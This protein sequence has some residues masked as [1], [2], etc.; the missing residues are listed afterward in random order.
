MKPQTP[1]QLAIAT[2]MEKNPEFF[3]S[4]RT[5]FPAGSIDVPDE[6]KE[7]I[8]QAVLLRTRRTPEQILAATIASVKSESIAHLLSEFTAEPD[9]LSFLT[10]SIRV[11]KHESTY[12]IERVRLAAQRAAHAR[13]LPPA[14][15]EVVYAATIVAAVRYLM[16]PTI[17]VSSPDD[18]VFTIVR[19]ALH[20]LDDLA[21]PE[22]QL[23]RQCL[24]WGNIDEVDQTY[25]PQ[26]RAAI[27]S[28]IR[29][30]L[31]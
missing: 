6:I 21:P 19:S 26:L 31:S 23:L 9:V 3:K 5:R 1:E 7:Q 27:A 2:H 13:V 30:V 16:A 11:G 12:E 29:N 18:V 22:A 14:Q 17:T 15:M 28:A 10:R 20:R 25:V 4:P 24:G 8:K